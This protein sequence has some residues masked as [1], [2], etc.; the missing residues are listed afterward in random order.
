MVRNWHIWSHCVCLSVCLSIRSFP[1]CVCLYY[2]SL[3]LYYFLFVSV[4]LFS[5]SVC[6]SLCA[7]LSVPLS[8]YHSFILLTLI[9]AVYIPLLS[10]CLSCITF[11]SFFSLILSLFLSS[12]SY[13]FLFTSVFKRH[14]TMKICKIFS[15][16]GMHLLSVQL[17]LPFLAVK[18]IR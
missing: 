13:A 9:Y 10:S 5:D 15:L 6:V 17:S 16:F 12:F 14:R 3:P 1:S 4:A 8:F 2:V 7:S 11:L 18:V